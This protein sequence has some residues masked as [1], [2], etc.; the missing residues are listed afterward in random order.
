MFKN[1]FTLFSLIFALILNS[2]NA[3]GAPATWTQTTDIDF[4]AGTLSGVIVEETGT[5]GSVLLEHAT[6]LFKR[7]IV[8]DNSG[9]TEL[10]DHQVKIVLTSSN[11]DF[12]KAQ[13]DGRDIRFLDSDDVTPLDFW[14]ES[15]DSASQTATV[16]VKVPLIPAGA[17]KTLFIYYG[18][19]TAPKADNG[20]AT[21]ELF[22][23]FENLNAW[24]QSG[25]TVTVNNGIV[26]LDSGNTPVIYRS[27]NIQSPFVVEVK[28]QHPSRYRNRLYLTTAAGSGSPTGYDYGIFDPSIYW[29]GLTGV[30]LTNNV[31]YIVRWEN[32]PNNYI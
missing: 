15:W 18:S 32:T 20:I 12:S 23:D 11:F 29:N 8:I 4:N 22:D 9:G 21:F 17:G 1:F 31:W 5:D 14:T 26:T 3:F 16:W 25:N 19:A 30:N 10:A 2:N 13:A 6:F 27:F 24:T 7:E 28:Y